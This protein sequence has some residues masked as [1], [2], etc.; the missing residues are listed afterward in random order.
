M[1]GKHGSFTSRDLALVAGLSGLYLAYG[2]FSSVTLRTATRSLDL[3]FLIAVL[4]TVLAGVTRRPWSAT[5]LG[6]VNGFIFLGTPAPFAAHITISLIANGLV[7][8]L[9][10]RLTGAESRRY[11]TGHMVMAGALGNFVMALVGL[12][13]LQAVGV[14]SPF[15][16][17]VIAVVG[18]TVVGALGAFLGTI[19]V[20]RV[21]DRVSSRKLLRYQ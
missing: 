2:Y 16:V 18:D 10:V 4:F 3:F 15:I 17:W 5:L 13:L 6:T 19:V 12:I 11:G 9:Y 7:F 21:G 20:R 8:D 14:A 1:K